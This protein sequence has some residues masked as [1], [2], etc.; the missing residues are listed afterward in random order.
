MWYLLLHSQFKMH[1]RHGDSKYRGA[2][3]KHQPEFDISQQA[4][5]II[6]DENAQCSEWRHQTGRSERV[7]GE[8]AR[9]TDT[10]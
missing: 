9:L 6:R 2:C 5:K 7:S 8:I 3:T 1:K 4:D 10:H